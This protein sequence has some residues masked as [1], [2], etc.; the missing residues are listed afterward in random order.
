MQKK[1]NIRLIG[2]GSGDN[3][4]ASSSQSLRCIY[5]D[6]D[7]DIWIATDGGI[8]R[9]DVNTGRFVHYAILNATRLKNAN[10]AYDIYEDEKGRLWIATYLGGLFVVNKNKLTA[11]DNTIPYLAEKNYSDANGSSPS[12]SN[13]VYKIEVDKNGFV[14][15][16]TQEG[17]V[18][19]DI[20]NNHIEKKD[21]YLDKM[22]YDGNDYIWY[23]DRAHHLQAF[24]YSPVM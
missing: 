14:W 17:L 1:D 2:S 16:N 21:I 15:V 4:H 12:L 23:S 24:I 19:I 7:K 18:R 20:R 9:Y 22:I 5:E 13:I 8:A 11:G 3:E 6:R 10:W